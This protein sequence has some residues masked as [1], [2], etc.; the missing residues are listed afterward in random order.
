MNQTTS[1]WIPHDLPPGKPAY[2]AIADAIAQDIR[3]GRL[4]AD[5]RLPPQRELAALLGLNFTTIS[6]AYSEA[7]RRGLIDARVGQGTF[8][9]GARAA[10]LS[11]RHQ[12]PTGF[13]LSMNLP[14]ETD[15]AELLQRMGSVL[16]RIRGDL[17]PALRYQPFGGSGAEREAAVAWLARRGLD[18]KADRTLV[19]PGTH[20][21]LDA[22]FS[23][24]V[25]PAAPRIA[26]DHLTYPGARAIAAVRAIPLVGL[27]SD[28]D[29]ILPEALESACREGGIAAL[30]CNPT[31]QNPTAVT[32]SRPRREA[33][34]ALVR[35]YGIPIIEDDVYG[36][37]PEDAPPAFAQLAPESTY[38]VS[39]LSK[40]LGA[41][42]RLA[43]LAV[44]D[45]RSAQARILATIR[46][47]TGMASPVSAAIAAEW[48][49]DGTAA[50]LLDFVRRESA[51]RQKIAA[52]ALAG[53]GGKVQAGGFHLWLELPQACSRVAF[54]SS[55]RDS[56]I[57]VVTS[58]AFTVT[59]APTEA[60]RICLGGAAS[61]EQVRSAM[62]QVAGALSQ[63][64]AIYSMIV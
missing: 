63:S 13:D 47:T 56:G 59:G 5:E 64:S 54:A 4:K 16:E 24:L 11:D 36:H 43:Y 39:G 25:T 17:R 38:H 19:C 48:I 40:T 14:P 20:S 3:Q 31:I 7:Q 42:L 28:G 27:E 23:A 12:R 33:I 41:G 22:L 62:D 21:V 8:V 52:D 58:D 1:Q 32:L 51:A 30:Y 34:V 44:P 15:D 45:L 29:G 18:A 10:V 46:A 35:R 2:V 37:I 53:L 6:R 60:V 9:R 49:R 55:L 26:C 61:R 57:G 50:A